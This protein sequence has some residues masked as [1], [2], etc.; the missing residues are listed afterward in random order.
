[1]HQL[2]V[3]TAVYMLV[4]AD[5]PPPGPWA[6]ML[7]KADLQQSVPCAHMLDVLICNNLSLGHACGAHLFGHRFASVHI[8]RW[9]WYNCNLLLKPQ[10]VSC[11]HFK[12]I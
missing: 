8:H 4:I 11:Y 12:H 3:Y 1:M 2:H 9:A 5:L 10:L 7:D 6:H